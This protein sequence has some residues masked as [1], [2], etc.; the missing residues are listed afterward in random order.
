MF[1]LESPYGD[2]SNEYTQYNIFD[3]KKKITLNYSKFAAI[4][5]SKGFKNEFE[6]AIVN[7]QSVSEPPKFY[8]RS[9]SL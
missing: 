9:R 6:T 8:C 1:S 7:K 3:I 4:G 5:F 2:D